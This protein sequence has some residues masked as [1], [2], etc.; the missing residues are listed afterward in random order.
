M[1]K[2]FA[3]YYIVCQLETDVKTLGVPRSVVLSI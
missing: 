2:G 1:A 3:N